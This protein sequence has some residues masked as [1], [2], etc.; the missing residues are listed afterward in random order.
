MPDF[1]L[2]K[3]E[4]VDLTFAL[5][6]EF[7]D[8]EHTSVEREL[9]DNRMAYLTKKIE[10]KLLVPFHWAKAILPNKKVLRMNGQHSSKA[11]I[12]YAASV[13]DGT[14][15]GG[16]PQGLKAHIDTY[17]VPNMLGAVELFRQIDAR[18]S[19]RSP[20]DVAGTYQMI[21][22]QIANL[23]RPN[24]KLAA[25]GISWELKTVQGI[26]HGNTGDDQYAK[27]GNEIYWPFITWANDLLDMKAPEFRKPAV[28]ASMYA[29]FEK[30]R[31]HAKTFW[32]DVKR[33]G[34]QFDDRAPA[35]VLDE[36][37]KNQKE[38]SDPKKR[39]KPAEIYA[40]CI[41]AFKAYVEDKEIDRI[42]VDKKKA[43]HE[44]LEE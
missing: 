6:K 25:E 42:R 20:A 43:L 30:D 28:V 18:Q 10:G 7:A 14:P 9:N 35:T 12:E 1:N 16:F 17:E 40:A 34:V 22:D 36:W 19:G 13:Q 33:G 8:M 3:S 5:A 37:L 11:L 21:N 31:E 24:A 23:P 29:T 2:V 26:V 41:Y 15:N 27:L 44:L 39:A 38:V 4:T 32:S